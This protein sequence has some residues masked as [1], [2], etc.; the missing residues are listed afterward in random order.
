M[1]PAK[2]REALGLKADASD[3]EVRAA[4]A[5]AG[6]APQ[7][8][9]AELEPA[10][11]GDASQPKAGQ[12]T[13]SAKAVPGTMTIDASAWNEREV[14]IKRL[15]AEA[16]KRAREERDQVIAAAVQAG[17]FAPSRKEHWARLWDADPEGTR[18]VLAGLQAN[19]VPVEATGYAGG[20]DEEFN[21][22][23]RQ[24]FPPTS[25]PARKG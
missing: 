19:V 4:L 8:A 2:M 20:E 13:A 6:L 3:D 25:E 18:Q 22:E 17:K 10:A 14:R 7:A 16:A 11:T 5:T 12:P 21:A 9:P 23:F 1:D 24:L 15:E